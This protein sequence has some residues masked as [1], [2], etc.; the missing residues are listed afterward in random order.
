MRIIHGEHSGRRITIP[1]QLRARPTTDQARENLFNILMNRYDM[2]NIRVLDLF[3]GT[4]SISYEF[5]SLGCPEVIC[6]ENDR[7]HVAGIQKNCE[8]IGLNA[9]NV[10][11]TDVFRFLSKPNRQFDIIFADPPYDLPILADIPTL[12]LN[13]GSMVQ[14]SLFILEHGPSNNFKE[15]SSWQ[16]T[17]KYGKV[18]FS[19]F[20][21]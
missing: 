10:I 11:R 1:K 15:N 9:I 18:H 12:V 21:I 16:E 5:A 14:N 19:F 20:S 6:I 4:G 7:F 13:S 17:R 8:T 2:T 3:A